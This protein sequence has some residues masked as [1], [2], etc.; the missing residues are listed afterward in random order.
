MLTPSTHHPLATTSSLKSA[1]IGHTR[2]PDHGSSATTLLMP[3]LL[4]R[5]LTLLLKLLLTLL[6]TLWPPAC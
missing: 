2:A 5:L 3:L 1:L 6:L 4:P